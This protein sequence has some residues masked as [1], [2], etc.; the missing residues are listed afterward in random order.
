LAADVQTRA[1]ALVTKVIAAH[2]FAHGF[3]NIELFWHKEFAGQDKEFTIIEIN[4]RLA[5]QMADFYA[6]VDGLD[7]YAMELAMALGQDPAS[8]PRT[9]A[10]HG[11]AASVVWR[12]FDGSSCPRQPSASDHSW[13]KSFMP[14]AQLHLFEKR[15]AQLQREMKWLGSHRWAIM[16]YAARNHHDLQDRY[17]AVCQRF[18]WPSFWAQ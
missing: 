14:D 13:L 3:F 8:V 12:S 15:G 17:L 7:V 6:H 4:P 18:G 16:N 11:A 5:A 9:A 10:R 2:G 1:K